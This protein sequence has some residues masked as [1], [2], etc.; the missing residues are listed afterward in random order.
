[1]AVSPSSARLAGSFLSLSRKKN[2]SFFCVLFFGLFALVPLNS[3]YFWL[4]M[5]DLCSGL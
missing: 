2:V 1:M 4:F 3:D 5:K